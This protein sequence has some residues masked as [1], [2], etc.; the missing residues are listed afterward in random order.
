[1]SAERRRSGSST[2]A[3]ITP[4]SRAGADLG[5]VVLHVR[6]EPREV[7]SA[8]VYAL[9]PGSDRRLSS[10]YIVYTAHLDHVGV[11]EPIDGDAIYNGAVDNASGVAGLLSIAKAFM[12]LPKAPARSILFVAT[13]GEEQG[14]IGAD[15]FVHHSP[16]P[17][18]R[19]AA[20]LNMDGLSFTKFEVAVVGGGSNSSL[21]R[22]AEEAAR[23][24]GMRVK[25]E[26]IGVG[27]S[28]HS[29]FLQGEDSSAVDPGGA[30][31]R[32]DAHALSHSGG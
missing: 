13:T 6:S 28:D 16:V 3:S 29:P 19:I 32:M 17:I 18:D 24:L 9:L 2:N 4:C 23:Q 20:S 12:A 1:M 11:G 21:G 8:N 5:S 7:Q 26:T 15:Y 22:M 14:E 25:N 30:D 27:G 31:R 10:E